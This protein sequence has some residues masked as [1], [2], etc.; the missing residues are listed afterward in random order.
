MN[1]QVI[2]RIVFLK[3]KLLCND[4]LIILYIC[5]RLVKHAIPFSVQNEYT[6]NSLDCV[7]KRKTGVTTNL[8][9]I[10]NRLVIHALPVILQH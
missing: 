1:T 2:Q 3:E 5:N 10:C 4:K 7:F 8:L 9:Y 6:G